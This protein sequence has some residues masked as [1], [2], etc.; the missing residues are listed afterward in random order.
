MSLSLATALVPR[1]GYERAAKIA[2]RAEAE[3]K[4]IRDVAAEERLMPDEE[5]DR[6]L[7]PGRLTG[8]AE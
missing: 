2:G 8:R 7:D 3:G 4:S 5:L 1:I 6:L